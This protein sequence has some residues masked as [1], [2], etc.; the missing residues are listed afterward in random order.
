MAAQG[1]EC[2]DSPSGWNIEKCQKVGK[3]SWAGGLGSFC[4]I[5]VFQ[6]TPLLDKG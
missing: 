2:V 6:S 1:M 3:I 4:I 5:V